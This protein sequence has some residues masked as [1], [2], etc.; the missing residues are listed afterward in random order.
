MTRICD[1]PV[2]DRP[3]ERLL[4]EGVE[5][6][7]NEELIA[8]LLNTGT[9]DISSKALSME[10]LSKAGTVKNLGTLT[11]ED[12]TTIKGIGPKKAATLLAAIELGRRVQREVPSILYKKICNAEDVYLYFVGICKDLE[13]EN[14]YCLYLD[15][16]KRVVANRLLFVGTMNYSLVHPREVFKEAYLHHAVSII[17][18]HN[19]PS[20]DVTPSNA[21]IELTSRL[22][23]A[24]MILGIP[25]EDHIIIGNNV[26]YSFF[27]D[28]R[29]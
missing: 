9:K 10:I 8:I 19:H 15:V 29:L 11:L 7:S 26:Y 17:C 13:Q 23:E 21:D 27:E 2:L 3:V 5:K 6:L 22:K 24:G 4:H 25:I 28:G 14:F 16:K 12:L 20:G 18:I 1:M